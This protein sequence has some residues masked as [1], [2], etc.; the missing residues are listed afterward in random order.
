MLV[1]KECHVVLVL[2]GNHNE[3]K[4]EMSCVSIISQQGLHKIGERARVSLTM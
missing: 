1:K 3:Q 2:K 4:E